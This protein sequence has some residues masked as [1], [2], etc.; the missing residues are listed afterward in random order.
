MGYNVISISLA[1]TAIVIAVVGW[2]VTYGH[3][4]KASQRAYRL[5]LLN[6]ARIAINESTQ[7]CIDWLSDLKARLGGLSLSIH[8]I[9]PALINM[10]EKQISEL[11]EALCAD[12]SIRWLRILEEYEVLLP[13]TRDV[14]IQL[15]QE[16]RVVIARVSAIH[17]KLSQEE[18]DGTLDQDIA[19]A[20]AKI[21]DLLGLIWDIRIYVQNT[22]LGDI[23]DSR[24]PKRMPRAQNVPVLYEDKQGALRLSCTSSTECGPTLPK[25]ESQ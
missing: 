7:A 11:A 6:E 16:Q 17:R 1:V 10:R 14:R 23:V 21:L 5:T 13:K 25:D 12:E 15:L 24:V 8:S 9:N 20:S 22:C 4:V 3:A 19:T 2:F 18:D